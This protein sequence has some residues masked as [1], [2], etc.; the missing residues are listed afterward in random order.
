M[1]DSESEV[2]SSGDV[3]ESRETLRIREWYY[4]DTQ[5]P[6]EIEVLN[7]AVRLAS[8]SLYVIDI[9]IRR[10]AGDEPEDEDYLFRV[11]ADIDFLIITLWKIRTVTLAAARRLPSDLALTDAIAEFDRS[12]PHLKLMRDVGQHLEDYMI[13]AASRRHRRPGTEYKISRRQL[14]VA[15]W[16]QNDFRWLDAVLDFTDS[17]K[18]ASVLY[19]R[20]RAARSKY[21]ASVDGK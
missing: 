8:N 7:R 5:Q 15:A 2:T 3:P 6:T 20:L 10:I 9:Q 14:E 4:N 18:A 16:S 19:S 1:T 17:R 11:W 21:T 12:V 13:N